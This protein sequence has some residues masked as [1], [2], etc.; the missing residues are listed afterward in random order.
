MQLAFDD[1]V[2][3]VDLL[4]FLRT[5][6]NETLEKFASRLFDDEHVTLLCK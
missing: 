5:C 1:E 3:L 6:D 4:N 2:Y